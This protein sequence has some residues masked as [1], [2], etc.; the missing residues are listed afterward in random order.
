MPTIS[1]VYARIISRLLLDA[2]VDEAELFR[3]TRVDSQAL[4]RSSELEL[5]PFSRLLLNAAALYKEQPIGFLI[6]SYHSTRALGP[7]GTAMSVAPDVRRGFQAL[8][9]FSALHTTYI[10]VHLDSR[11]AGL[12]VRL[13]FAREAE[14]VLVSHMEATMM[15][16]RNYVEEH[17]T[18]ALNDAVFE[19]PY[20]TPDYATEYRRHLGQGIVFGQSAPA[21]FLPAHW[22]DL[23]SPFYDAAEWIQSQRRLSERVKE[24]G[25]TD[26]AAYQ[27]QVRSIL[28]SE[29]PPLPGLAAIASRL[30][31]SQRTLNRRLREEG[32][33]FR[34]LRADLLDEWA[35][36]YL[37]ETR[38]S[39]ESIAAALGYGDA[40]NF[41]RAF[42]ARHNMAPAS[43]RENRS[44]QKIKVS[45]SNA[46]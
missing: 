18:R 46:T 14:A 27:R 25:A 36:N 31:V 40:A 6:G 17:T 5:E 33:S 8:A 7:M 29:S 23:P 20:P 35:R 9:S 16:F 11:V 2:G 21:M 15:L 28:R 32:A 1:P 3:G 24:I 22:L 19:F 4:W 43:Y 44:R 26:N 30:H 42:R 38:D 41:R 34:E 45:D 13:S 37:V 39:I 12:R 10:R